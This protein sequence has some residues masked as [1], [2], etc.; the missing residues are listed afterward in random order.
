ME[1]KDI[2]KDERTK[3][4]IKQTELA[5]KIGVKQK[6]ISRW[7]TGERTPNIENLKKICQALEVSADVMLGIKK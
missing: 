1:F 6:D 4:G 3:R 5:E 7:E 2:L